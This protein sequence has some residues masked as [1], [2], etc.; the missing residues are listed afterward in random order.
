MSE[1]RSILFASTDMATTSTAIYTSTNN[2]H[3]DNAHVVNQSGG[4]INLTLSLGDGT[5][6]VDFYTTEAIADGATVQ[7]TRIINHGLPP[8]GA[9]KATAS[10]ANLQIVISGRD[11]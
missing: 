6:D 10:A 4:A 8:G 7:L 5:T 3:I 1:K 11:F 2:T 9:I